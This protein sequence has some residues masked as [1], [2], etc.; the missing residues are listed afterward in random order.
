[1]KKYDALQGIRNHTRLKDN[2]F[3]GAVCSSD[4]FFPFRDSIDT[5]ARVGVKAVIQPYGSN[6]DAESIDAANEH[7]IA[8][9]ATLERCFG[10]F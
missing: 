6:R 7:K 4:A 9:P 8:M 1:M 2:P 10:H 3:N 5:L